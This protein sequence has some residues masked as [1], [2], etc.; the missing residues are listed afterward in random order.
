MHS[1]LNPLSISSQIIFFVVITICLKYLGVMMRMDYH[2]PIPRPFVLIVFI[3]KQIHSFF[4]NNGTFNCHGSLL[5]L[6]FSNNA[7]LVVRIYLINLLY[8]LIYI[9]L[10]YVFQISSC[11]QTSCCERAHSF[12]NF[13]EENFT[14]IY[15]F[16]GSVDWAS[17]F[18]LLDLDSAGSVIYDA[19][20]KSSLDF[21]PCSYYRS[22]SI[23]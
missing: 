18:S 12:F 1:P 5:D 21:V 3:Y 4:Q 7:F 6:V 15:L 10:H 17:T 8:P 16:I 13:R 19:L 22:N 14:N 20:H 23:S 9:T 11:A 2:T